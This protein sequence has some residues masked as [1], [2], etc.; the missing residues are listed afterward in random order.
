MNWSLRTARRSPLLQVAKSAV[1][2]LAAWLLA[3]WL[4]PGPVPVFAAIAALL[5]VQPSISQSF[6]RGIERTVGVIAG[7]I[8]ASAIGIVLGTGFWAIALAVVCALLLAWALRTTP[9]T[10]NQVA[11][12]GML[13]LALGTATPDYALD[14]ILE[15][16]I[17]AVIGLVVNVAIVP[18]LALGPARARVAALTEDTA[19]GLD[20]L[21][22]ALVATQD[23][24]RLATLLAQARALRG[25]VADAE[26]AIAEARDS[27]ALNPRARRLTTEVDA[28]ADDVHRL[29]AIVTQL[30]G[31]TRAF[32]D[33]YDDTIAGDRQVGAIAEQLHRAAHDIRLERPVG[34]AEVAGDASPLEASPGEPPAL[35]RPLELRTAPPAHWVLI[36]SLLVDLRRIHAGVAATS[37]A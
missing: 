5:T 6:G 25:T 30:I 4:I 24:D 28:L 22:A 26:A 8:V 15:T 9:G 27:L 7:V 21:G 10:A 16:A 35:T 32:V 13:V 20:R 12:S 18:P 23:A 36:G 37:D 19:A 14:R 17:G 11:I 2:T 1:A 33:D 31:M 34:A 29:F 3:G